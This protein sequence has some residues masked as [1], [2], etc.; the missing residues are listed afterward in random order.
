M[1][2]ALDEMVKVFASMIFAV[3]EKISCADARDHADSIECFD[4]QTQ[5]K[6]PPSQS[7][8]SYLKSQSEASK[9]RWPT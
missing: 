1:T 5:N 3:D 7:E 8:E 4:H 2:S 6:V 9:L